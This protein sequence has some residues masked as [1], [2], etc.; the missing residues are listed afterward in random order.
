MT[1]IVSAIPGRIRLRDKALRQS[2]CL[3]DLQAALSSVSGVLAAEA[4]PATGSLLLHYDSALVDRATMEMQAEAAATAA[5]EGTG[6]PTARRRMARQF[7][8]YSKYGMLGSLAVS[9]AYAAAG[10]KRLHALTGGLFGAFLGVHM[11]VHRRHLL[12]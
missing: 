10:K 6:A 3:E 2:H 12:K 8:R 11:L 5:L 1:R 4:N 7:N 9:M